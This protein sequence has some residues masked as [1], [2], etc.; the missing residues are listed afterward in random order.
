VC[1]SS[2]QARGTLLLPYPSYPWG[3]LK[4]FF[5]KDFFEKRKILRKD[6]GNTYR[7]KMSQDRVQQ[8]I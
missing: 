3:D 8:K 1:Y 4:V 5:E 7:D 6:W 2:G